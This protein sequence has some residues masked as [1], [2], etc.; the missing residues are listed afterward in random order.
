MAEIP[1]AEAVSL[2]FQME[3]Q[4]S[5]LAVLGSNSSVVVPFEMRA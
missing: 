3:R 1:S 4:N 2:F 5:N